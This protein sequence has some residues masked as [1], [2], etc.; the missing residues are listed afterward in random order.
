M[1]LFNYSSL[2]NRDTKIYSIGGHNIAGGL[3]INW[4]SVVGPAIL[5]FIILGWLI[6][7]PFK[8]NFFNPLGDNF[9][10]AF[11]LIF[12]GLGIVCG[13]LLWYVQFSGY[14]LYQYLIAYFKPKKVY[15][16]EFKTREYKFNKIKI[17]SMIKTIL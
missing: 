5:V 7:I 1:V 6:S 14:R 9:V 15:T 16:N 11:T 12:L 2:K 10:P 3:S 8:I 13:C 4:I 17:D